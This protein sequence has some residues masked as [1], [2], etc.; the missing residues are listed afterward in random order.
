MHLPVSLED[1][2]EKH[3][4]PLP[5]LLLE[6]EQIRKLLKQTREQRVPPLRDD[7]I[8]TAWNAMMLE[9][10]VLAAEVLQE[11]AYLQAA[12]QTAN[13]LWQ[14]NRQASG[15]LWRIHWQ[16]SSS[17]SGNQQDYAYFASAL[18]NLYDQTG[19]QQWLDKA[20][21]LTSI[22]IQQFWDKADYGFYE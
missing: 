9:S 19:D 13:W 4:I 22:M 6:V 1:Y 20:E 2:A 21:Q 5:L 17:V 7:K 15:E 11:P 14:T 3:A 18:I 12:M 8:I 10:L 16:G